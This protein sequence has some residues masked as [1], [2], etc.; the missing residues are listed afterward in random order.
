MY[1][2]L[3]VVPLRS[4]ISRICYVWLAGYNTTC[5]A[6]VMLDPEEVIDDQV[7]VSVVRRSRRVLN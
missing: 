4:H 6:G 2:L 7:W 1:V 3:L 5:R